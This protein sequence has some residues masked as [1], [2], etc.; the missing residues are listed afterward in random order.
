MSEATERYI[1]G[2][3]LIIL[4]AIVYILLRPT[5][6]LGGLPILSTSILSAKK[7]IPEWILYTMPDAVWFAS[8]LCFQAPLTFKNGKLTGPTLTVIACLV[9]PVHETL[10]IL[11]WIPGTFCMMDMTAYSLI[12][13]LYLTLCFKKSKHQESDSSH[14]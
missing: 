12:I 5:D 4:G 14:L 13:V 11:P 7:D 8:L 9:A 2:T 10:Q 6:I 1:I 3:L